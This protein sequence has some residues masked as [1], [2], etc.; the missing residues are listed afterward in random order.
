MCLKAKQMEM[1]PHGS[2]GSGLRTAQ[3]SK[4]PMICLESVRC[5]S[6]LFSFTDFYVGC[7]FPFLPPSV[8]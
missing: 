8:K 6:I 2:G 5:L 4:A 1:T 7:I 3:I